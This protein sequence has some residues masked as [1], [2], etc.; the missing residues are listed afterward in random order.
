MSG[1]LLEHLLGEVTFAGIRLSITPGVYVP[2][3]RS[4]DLARAVATYAPS[5]TAVDVCCGCGA[6]ARLL[7]HLRADLAVLATDLDPSAVLAARAND[8]DAVVADLLDAPQVHAAAPLAAV[9][10]VAPYVPSGEL[11]ALDRDTLA[12]IPL[13]ALDGGDDGL[14][15]VRRLI[16]QARCALSPG[17]VLGLE[18]GGEQLTALRPDLVGFQVVEHLVDIDGSAR[19]VVMVRG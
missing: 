17:G 19:G 6:L 12:H 9:L 4:A 16:S 15:I 5:G 1:E 11:P 2:R 8:V 10:A 7:A 13:T 3:P 18:L 14:H